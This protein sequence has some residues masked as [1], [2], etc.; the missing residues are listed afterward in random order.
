MLLGLEVW[1]SVGVFELGEPNQALRS[2]AL[3]ASGT[4]GY[5]ASPCLGKV[6]EERQSWDWERRIEDMNGG[7][8]HL[9]H[10][11][12]SAVRGDPGGRVRPK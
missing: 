9:G 12:S 6:G 1:V 8:G 7:H 3:K 4:A 2:L 5:V 10:Q 11:H